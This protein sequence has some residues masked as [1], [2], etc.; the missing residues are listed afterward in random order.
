MSEESKDIIGQILWFSMFLSPFICIILC[1][2]FLEIKTLF[3]VIIGLI[4]GNS[5]LCQTFMDTK[6]G[7]LY[8][9]T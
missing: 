4:A 8:Q 2:K 7:C 1:W 9:A 5:N 3:R 6:K